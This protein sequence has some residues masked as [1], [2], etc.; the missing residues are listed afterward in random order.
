MF[1]FGVKYKRGKRT[2]VYTFLEYGALLSLIGFGLI[3]L[4]WSVNYGPLK[5]RAEAY[6]G[7]HPDWF[8]NTGML[9]EWILILGI[10]FLIVGYL[11]ANLMYR[12]YKFLLSEH[13]FHISKGIFFI[14]ERTVPYQQISNVHIARPYLYRFVGLARLDIITTSDTDISESEVKA[15]NFY[16]PLIDLKIARALSHQLLTYTSESGKGQKIKKLVVSER[17]K[18]S[19]DVSDEEGDTDIEDD[20]SEKEGD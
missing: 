2:F 13:G 19:D 7:G 5:G 12:Q 20:E 1:E 6:L 15:K 14:N 8:V 10:G 11:R 18:G 16:I 17:E 9:A 3:Y 4:A